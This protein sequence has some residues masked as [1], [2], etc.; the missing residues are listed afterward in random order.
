MSFVIQKEINIGS[1]SFPLG[2]DEE[3]KKQLENWLKI[4]PTDFIPDERSYLCNKHFSNDC[5]ED[6]EN[7]TLRANAIPSESVSK[8]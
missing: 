4:C 6:L 7:L 1:Y 8:K 3:A 5:F 2:N